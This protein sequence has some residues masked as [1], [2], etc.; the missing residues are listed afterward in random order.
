METTRVPSR[1]ERIIE[2]SFARNLH[3]AFAALIYTPFIFFG[4]GEQP[5]SYLVVSTG[6]RLLSTGVYSPSRRPGSLVYEVS[7]AVLD[8]VGGSFLSNLGTLVMSIVFLAAFTAVLRHL[9]IRLRAYLVW[10]VILL[11]LYWNSSTVTLDYVWAMA[12][13]TVGFLYAIKRQYLP[14]TLFWALSVGTRL[15]TIVTL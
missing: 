7:Q 6:R 13:S 12:L 15:N 11:P 4:Y 9:K 14:A 2:R 5:D 8:R 10:I 3:L 1:W